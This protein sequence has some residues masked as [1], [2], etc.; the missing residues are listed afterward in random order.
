MHRSCLAAVCVLVPFV[1]RAD[2]DAGARAILERRCLICHNST[3]KTSDLDVSTREG[4]LRGGSKGPALNAAAP[5][6]SLFYLRV[7]SGQMP[8][9]APLPAQEK[10]TLRQWLADGARWTGAIE[11]K[12]ADLDWW[13]LQPLRKHSPPEGAPPE[14]SRALID[15]WIYAKLRENNLA[16]SQRADRTALIRRVTFELLGLPP[17]PEQ[18]ESFVRDTSP[19]AYESLVDRLLSSPHYGEQ[20]ARHWMDVARFAESEGFERDWLR[21]H[22]WTYR[23]YLIRAFNSDIPYTRFAKEQIAGDVL[24]PVTHDSIAATGFLVLGPFDAVGFTS[25]V[26]QERESVRED[27]LEEMVGTV[28]QT[29]LGLTVNCA[30]CHDHKFDPISQ[31]DYYRFKAALEGVWQPTVDNDLKADGRFL[32]T[33]AE[34][35]ERNG[36]IKAIEN[37]IAVAEAAIAGL[38]QEARQRLPG[39]AMSIPGGL[40]A[41]W[42]FDVDTR[43]QESGLHAAHSKSA[44]I[45][46][47]KLSPA[48]GQETVTITT[49]PLVS[50]LREKTLEAFVRVGKIP[51][52]AVT[53][54]Q[55]RNRSGFR[56][57]ASDGIRFTAGKS[58]QWENQSNV[59]FRSQD[60]KGTP[61]TAAANALIH[62]AVVYRAD[63]TIRIYR[64]G[65]PYGQPY[66]PD[67]ALAA[68]QLQTYAKGDAVV[69]LIA[70]KDLELEEAR[71]YSRALGDAEVSGSFQGWKGDVTEQS[72]LDAMDEPDRARV[73]E[74]KRKLSTARVELDTMPTPARAFAASPRQPEPTHLLIRGDVNRK[75]E[76]VTP[77]A[78]SSIRSLPGELGLAPDAAESERRR[79]LAGW[80]ANPANPLFARVMVNRV[81]HHHFGAGLVENPNDFGFN[82][83]R[84]SHPEL[85]DWL[86]LEFAGNG[87]SLKKLHKTILLSEAYQQSSQF[88]G[89]AAAKDAGNRL[90]WRFSPHRLSGEAARDAML[91]ASGS[92]NAKM[93]GPSFRPFEIVKNAGSYRSYQPVESEDPE[94]QRRTVYRMNVNSGGNPM[95]DSL[96]CPLPSVKTPRR[97]N[98]TTALQALSLM[99]NAFVGRM[100]KSFALRL[101]SERRETAARVDRAFRLALG[102]PPR[103]EEASS[104]ATLVESHGL[105]ALCWGLLNTSEFLYVR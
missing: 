15:R 44:L 1:S 66:Q 69:D 70:T 101:E 25:A 105:E 94:L 27:E 37:R 16:P 47:G 28:S 45:R 93:Y 85:L 8:P 63:N 48:Q 3:T 77:G 34:Q 36:R 64:N 89:E 20:W 39:S 54:L 104:S 71:I 68:G 98:T 38:Y 79:A 6:E 90:L 92:L 60:V 21:D 80:I 18:V 23:D 55:I 97:L 46:E 100:A 58:N 35:A 102:R 62:I 103:P 11:T 67:P 91:A 41:R 40:L 53:L 83:G 33:T 61:E 12:H 81:W 52:K 42:S 9:S 72:L 95:L 30:R 76:Q 73:E 87:Y 56:G 99:N 32:L 26:A 10:E 88:R 49:G 22:A 59:R 4:M 5:L 29:F 51:E 7:R 57:A 24:E 50:D 86:A 13:S 84:P 31:K 17:T 82:G 14:W 65:E 96:D 78:V 43:D 2:T 74:W 19:N 75:A